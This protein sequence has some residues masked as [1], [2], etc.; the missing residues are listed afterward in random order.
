M[1]W[2]DRSSPSPSLS[3]GT[4]PTVRRRSQRQ[5]DPWLST[6]SPSSLPR[7]LLTHTSPYRVPVLLGLAYALVWYRKRIGWDTGDEQPTRKGDVEKGPSSPA[8]K[9]KESS[10][11]DSIKDQA[12][13]QDSQ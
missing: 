8:I 2:Y 1:D 4:E 3:L 9:T 10:T 12:L 5:L 7:P 11:E 6:S 13:D